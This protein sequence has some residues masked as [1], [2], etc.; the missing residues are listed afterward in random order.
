MA[1]KK[2]DDFTQEAQSILQH[3]S[4]K[5]DKTWDAR[6]AILAMKSADSR[7]WRKME[8]IGHYFEF[9]CIKQ[10]PPGLQTPGKRYGNVEFDAQGS[11]QWDFKAHAI[12]SGR[13]VIGNDLEA[14][15][16]AVRE[17][18][19]VGLLVASGK[20]EYNDEDRTFQKWHDTLKGKKSKFVREREKRGAPSR[21]RKV[22]FDMVRL[23]VIRIDDA[24]LRESGVFKQGRNADGSPRRPKVLIDL[25]KLGDALIA[26][27]DY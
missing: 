25:E 14:T 10:P 20:A 2:S 22:L 27:H 9:L 6:K 12:N 23:A 18:G 19:S 26:H 7:H 13:L 5:F 4:S 1:S 3:Y 24:L 8:W 17:Y 11:Y 15:K 16:S 21:L